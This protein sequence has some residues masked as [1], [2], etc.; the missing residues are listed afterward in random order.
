[1]KD[2]DFRKGVWGEDAKK[3]RRVSVL[4]RKKVTPINKEQFDELRKI[5][6][7]SVLF[8]VLSDSE[9][10]D[11]ASEENDHD[12]LPKSLS[13]VIKGHEITGNESLLPYFNATQIKLVEIKTRSQRNSLWFTQRC[14]RLTS[15]KFGEILKKKKVS[16]SFIENF[17]E[18]PKEINVPSVKW[19]REKEIKGFDAYFDAEKRKHTNFSLKKAGLFISTSDPYL[20]CSPDGIVEC[21][22]CGKGVLEV[23][24]PYKFRN[25]DPRTIAA[26]DKKFCMN[27]DGS[28]KEEHNYY[29]QVQGQMAITNTEYCD[30]V[31]WTTI[32]L[33]IRRIRRDN[34]FWEVN[35][36]T[37]EEFYFK[38][39]MPTLKNKEEEH[40]SIKQHGS[41]LS[42]L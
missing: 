21:D 17:T 26:T 25:V 18:I 28:L 5:S 8:T 39:V 33:F 24:C 36:P 7:N 31:I 27:L 6:P 2:I 34:H 3:R 10:T 35:K 11:T 16:Q 20:G 38:H 15:S 1:M 40:T 32:D 4:P 41:S 12:E 42:Q 37:L 13:E 29:A 23:K 9:D 19:G 14:G 22:C 30:F